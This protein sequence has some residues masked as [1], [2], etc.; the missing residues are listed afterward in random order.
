MLYL[1]RVDR[2]VKV[3][4][5]RMELDEIE[6]VLLRHPAVDRGAVTVPVVD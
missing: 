6:A 1:G 3:A 2:Q 4:G 5:V